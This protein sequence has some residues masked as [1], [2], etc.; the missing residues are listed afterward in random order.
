MHG[1]MSRSRPPTKSRSSYFLHNSHAT[2]V[3]MDTYLLIGGDGSLQAQQLG[4][5]TGDFPTPISWHSIFSF[6]K[7]LPER[8]TFSAQIQLGHSVS[9]N[10]NITLWLAIGFTT[11]LWMSRSNA[12]L[13]ASCIWRVGDSMVS[14]MD[15]SQAR[16]PFSFLVIYSSRASLSIPVF[17]WLFLI[18]L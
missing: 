9:F 15:N 2:I 1:S 11:S 4:R 14:K 7:S 8:R 16:L 6:W 10:H 12:V 13:V 5:I 3:L 17:K 18:S